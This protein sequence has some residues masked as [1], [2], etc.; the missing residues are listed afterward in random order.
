MSNLKTIR[1]IAPLRIA[2]AGGGTDLFEYYSKY[3]GNVLNTT[4][5]LKVEVTIEQTNYDF[6]EYISVDT[7]QKIQFSRNSNNFSKEKCYLLRKIHLYLI[8]DY[9]ELQ[10]ICI[11]IISF[12]QVPYGS[13]LGTSSTICVA[14]IQGL[15]EMI[16]VKLTPHALAEYAFEIERIKLKIL[17]GCQDHYA[18]AIGGFNFIEMSKNEVIANSLLI[19]KDIISELE[20]STILA[21]GKK[22]RSSSNIIKEQTKSMAN[23]IT[24]DSLHNS[25]LLAKELKNKLIKQQLNEFFEISKKIWEIKK[26]YASCIVPP[27]YENLQKSLLQLGAYSCKISGAGGGGFLTT[28]VD[29]GNKKAIIE[30]LENMKFKIFSFSF[31]EKGAKSWVI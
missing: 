6:N 26:Q 12:S 30:H 29:P 21:I 8:E 23:Q 1:S 24:I 17:G 22:T 20:L 18:A 16:S 14:L 10:N 3:G 4:L 7:N 27:E 2:F 19:N 15:L 25:K 11:K 31:T 13:G 9:P 28:F 5:S